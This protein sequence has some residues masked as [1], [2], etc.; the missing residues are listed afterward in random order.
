MLFCE[1]LE[2]EKGYTLKSSHDVASRLNRV[3][4]LLN[5][6]NVPND[7]VLKMMQLESFKGLSMSVRSQLRRTVKLYLEYRESPNF[8]TTTKMSFIP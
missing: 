7:A 1:W 2:K 8:D 5:T 4:L 6:D 3:R